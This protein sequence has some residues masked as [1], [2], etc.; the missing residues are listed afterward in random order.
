MQGNDGS[1]N[2]VAENLIYLCRFYRLE[3]FEDWHIST[4]AEDE[5][6][7]LE[8][9]TTSNSTLENA[10]Q[11]YPNVAVEV[12]A[13]R[14][15]L[16]YKAIKDFMIRLSEFEKRPRGQAMKRRHVESSSAS[17]GSNSLERKIDELLYHMR[18]RGPREPPEPKAKRSKLVGRYVGPSLTAPGPLDTSKEQYD[19]MPK[20]PSKKSSAQISQRLGWNH[21]HFRVCL[22]DVSTISYTTSERVQVMQVIR[23]GGTS[24]SAGVQEDSEQESSPGEQDDSEQ[25]TGRQEEQDRQPEPF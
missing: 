25:K 12:L 19:D 1:S 21:N 6:S 16:D 22:E 10:V 15:G 3:G 24:R 11:R 7:D 14:I 18:S 23:E 2:G 13:Q 5:Q 8:D 20:S 17:T 4:G 9:F